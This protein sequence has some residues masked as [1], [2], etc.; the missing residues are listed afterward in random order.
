MVALR[1]VALCM[2]MVLQTLLN[3]AVNQM[4]PVVEGAES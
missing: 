3:A 4:A 2:L 1:A